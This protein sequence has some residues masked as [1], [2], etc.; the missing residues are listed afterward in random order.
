MIKN[1]NLL[2]RL[3]IPLAGA[4][5][6]P[7]LLFEDV[8]E[9]VSFWSDAGSEGDHEVGGLIANVESGVDHVL[10]DVD[11]ITGAEDFFLIADPL[12]DAAGDAG[13]HFFL[14]RVLMKVVAFSGEELDVDDG[15]VLVPSGRGTA[16]P[17]EFSPVE[18]FGGRL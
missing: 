2:I 3:A 5:A 1:E 17:G 6:F 18:F 10:T 14:I 4:Q 11:G 16:Q 12:L 8:D 15:E 9:F 7:R 13:D